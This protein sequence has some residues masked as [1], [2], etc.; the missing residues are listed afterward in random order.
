MDT[1][2]QYSEPE[3]E[4]KEV[5]ATPAENMT[6]DELIKEMDRLGNKVVIIDRENNRL[7]LEV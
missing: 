5:W 6:I 1:T 2:P 3:V 7:G 4:L